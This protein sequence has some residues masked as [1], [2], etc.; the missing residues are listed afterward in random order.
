MVQHESQSRRVGRNAPRSKT[1]ML[2]CSAAVLFY[3]FFNNKS[4]VPHSSRR[5]TIADPCHCLFTFSGCN[6]CLTRKIKCDEQRPSCRRCT[7]LQLCCDWT[8]RRRK[9]RTISKIKKRHTCL[10]SRPSQRLIRPLQSRPGSS[11]PEIPVQYE[12]VTPL[13]PST[14]SISNFPEPSPEEDWASQRTLTWLCTSQGHSQLS[15]PSSTSTPSIVRSLSTEHIPCANSLILS[16]HDRRCL[17]Y[18]PSSTMVL[19]YLKPWQWSNLSY[20]YQKTASNDAIVMRMILAMS[21]SEMHRIENGS[22]SATAN[23]SH[24]PGLFHYNLAV[25]QLSVFLRQ[26]TGGDAKQRLE[27]LL[28][29]LL[30]MVEYEVRFGY[31]RHHLRL[32][33]Q[34]VRSLFESY[35]NLMLN[36]QK[37]QQITSAEHAGGESEVADSQLSLLSSQLLLWIS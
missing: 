25:R 34:G 19:G 28:A 7:S 36:R 18:Y 12:P 29:A 11:S 35:E 1:G 37:Q 9:S 13:S 17:E 20:I 31:S 21:A 23:D 32:H 8:A 22:N 6:T 5:P 16:P 15:I 2:N 33:L 30:F 24:D 26:E 14:D 3:Q 27:R 4:L 10:N